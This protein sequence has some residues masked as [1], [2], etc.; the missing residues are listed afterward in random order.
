MS[1]C[2]DKGVL[3]ET[4]KMNKDNFHF[5]LSSVKKCY[6]IH[7]YLHCYLFHVHPDDSKNR[8]KPRQLKRVTIAQDKTES[9][10]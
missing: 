7:N 6:R 3:I 8:I 10:S 9:N 1:T 5:G 2:K 4:K